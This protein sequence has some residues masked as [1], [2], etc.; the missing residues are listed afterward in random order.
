MR[1]IQDA[2]MERALNNF[3][4][5]QSFWTSVRSCVCQR[6]VLIPS[7]YLVITRRELRLWAFRPTVW[8]CYMDLLAALQP[9]YS[10]RK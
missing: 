5:K 3:A 1:L 6:F 9:H 2:L 10:F 8:L 7:C 4:R